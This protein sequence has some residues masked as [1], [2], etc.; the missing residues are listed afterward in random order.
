MKETP[1]LFSTDMVKAILD[2]AKTQT[3]RVMKPQPNLLYGVY[4]GKIQVIH[5]DLDKEGADG[6]LDI[7]ANT[8]VTE[9]QLYG[10]KRWE[11]IF[12]DKIQRLREEGFSGLVSISRAR[13]GAERIFS[14]FLIPQQYQGNELSSSASVYGFPREA[15]QEVNASQTSGRELSQQQTRQS[16]VGNSIRELAGQENA[17]SAQSL[18]QQSK[19]KD[20]LRGQRAYPLGSKQGNSQQKIYSESVRNEPTIHIRNLPWFIG[21]TLW[22]R[23]T[24]QVVSFSLMAG[25]PKGLKVA[26]KADDGTKIF[27]VSFENWHKYSSMGYDKW[28]PSIHMPRYASRITL[29]ITELWAELLRSISPADAMAEGGYTV[30]EFIKLYLKINHLPDDANPWNWV[31]SF[32]EVKCI[33]GYTLRPLIKRTE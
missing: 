22:V 1:I 17:Q 33:T 20:I 13:H 4:G 15:S 10:G 16:D 21:Q 31:I 27:K 14:G 25:D 7:K 23:E 18:L 26:Y 8:S 12:K 11:D 9:R 29:E 6:E 3:R 19:F 32:K 5:N 2:G 30:E 24:W 28:R